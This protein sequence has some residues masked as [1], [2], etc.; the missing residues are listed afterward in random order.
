MDPTTTDDWNRVYEAPGA[1]HLFR[2]CLVPIPLVLVVACTP[3]AEA[4][5]P[6]APATAQT[7]SAPAHEPPAPQAAPADPYRPEAAAWLK[8]HL[9]EAI[10][11]AN[12]VEDREPF[13]VG[14]GEF[15]DMGSLSQTPIGGVLEVTIV[16]TTPTY[17]S[18][19][20]ADSACRP[21]PWPACGSVRASTSS[22][23]Q[24]RWTSGASSPARSGSRLW[25][26]PSEPYP[27]GS[28][29]AHDASWVPPEAQVVEGQQR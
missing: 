19:S 25:Q 18:A 28:A 29:A 14:L 24:R 27:R 12:D 21:P 9:A 1:T 16:P 8:Q 22:G 13:P 5:P 15:N 10:Q 7:A 26:N 3:H 17:P 2:R 20:S 11:F 23:R 6:V 4:P